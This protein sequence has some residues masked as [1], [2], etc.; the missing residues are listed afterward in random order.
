MLILDLLMVVGLGACMSLSTDM[1]IVTENTLFCMP[2]TTIGHFCDALSSYYL[3][4]LK[5]YYGRYITL[6]AAGLKAED[7]LHLGLATHYVPSRRLN[8][9]V[10]HL[11]SL[12]MP[13]LHEIQQETR[14]FT[15]EMPTTVRLTSTPYISQHEKETV[16]EHC[17]KFDTVEE[18]VAALEAEGSKFSLACKAKILAASPV[19]T[20]VTLELLRRAP[21]LS[22]TECLFLERHLWAIDIVCIYNT[23]RCKALIHTAYFFIFLVFA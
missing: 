14:K 17:F 3:S 7:L 18:I 11:T 5:G 16:I 19:A 8:D 4:R 23:L 1:R 10:Q 15:E 2:E 20:K 22:L 12:N 21:S 6:C 13:S 9:M